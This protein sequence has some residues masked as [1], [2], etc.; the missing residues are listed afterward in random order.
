LVKPEDLATII[1]Y[2]RTTGRATKGVMLSHN[3]IVS[4]AAKQLK[5]FHLKPEKSI[6]KLSFACIFLKE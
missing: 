2:I 4:D 5:K 6:T 3:N 1:L